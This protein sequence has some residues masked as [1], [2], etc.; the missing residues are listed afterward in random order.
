[1]RNSVTQEKFRLDRLEEHSVLLRASG[2]PESPSAIGSNESETI[3]RVES[4]LSAGA[5]GTRNGDEVKLFG[6]HDR[7]RPTHRPPT[8]NV[9]SSGSSDVVRPI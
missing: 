8:L 6:S 5:G 4:T 2:I 3:I 1:M 7:S 9:V